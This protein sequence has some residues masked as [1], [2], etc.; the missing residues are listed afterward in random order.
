MADVA[1]DDVDGVGRLALLP[2]VELEFP[3][4][5]VLPGFAVG[6]LFAG[7]N[8]VKALTLPAITGSIA[9]TTTTATNVDSILRMSSSLGHDPKPP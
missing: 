4:P 3:A 7:F 1:K 5:P 9:P 2:A 6:R 8:A